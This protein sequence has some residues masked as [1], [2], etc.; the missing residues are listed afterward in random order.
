MTSA[1]RA[2]GSP[3]AA[4]LVARL[5]V[6]LQQVVAHHV[7]D[8]EGGEDRDPAHFCPGAR[9]RYWW[10]ARTS[11]VT[12]PAEVPHGHHAAHDARQRAV[13]AVDDDPARPAHRRRAEGA[14]RA[15]AA[16]AVAPQVA[17]LL[18][19]GRGA[20]RGG[21]RAERLGPRQRQRR[22]R[23]VA[24]RLADRERP[25]VEP[26]L[27]R[28]ALRIAGRGE[29]DTP[30]GRVKCR[31]DRKLQRL[32]ELDERARA[33]QPVAD[34]PAAQRGVDRLAGY[35]RRQLRRDL[36]ERPTAGGEPGPQDASRDEHADPWLAEAPHAATIKRAALWVKGQPVRGR[37]LS[38]GGLPR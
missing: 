14:R 23:L 28:I 35:G 25:L 33:R 24:L 6:G 9:A 3:E 1:R 36:R 34:R 2:R 29:R 26:C 30:G 21:L 20:R 32:G 38:W 19:L 13:A 11:T 10:P 4:A 12:L 15:E 17:R 27:L 31:A 37:L 16:L 7:G 5:P 8:E 18:A 22:H